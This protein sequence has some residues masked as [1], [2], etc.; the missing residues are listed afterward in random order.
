MEACG[1]A[2]L[3]DG[4]VAIG[5]IR[6]TPQSSDVVTV[7]YSSGSTG[8][9]KGSML[10]DASLLHRVSG[11]LLPYDPTVICSFM[12]LYHSFDRLNIL[13][14]MVVGGRIAFHHGSVAALTATLREVRPTS[15]SSTPLFWNM[16]HHEFRGLVASGAA[17]KDA[18]AIVRGLL[19]GRVKAIGTGGVSTAPEVLQ[20][21]RECWRCSV[22]DGFG[23]TEAGR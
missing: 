1:R 15:F 19:G 2:L 11:Q 9:P 6:D 7:I 20:F 21:M 3:A 17:R 8:K 14:H 16:P 13:A 18:L 22:G 5:D 10:S 23:A 12:P 4:S